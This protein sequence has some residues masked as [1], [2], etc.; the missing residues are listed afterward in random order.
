MALKPFIETANAYKGLDRDGVLIPDPEHQP[1]PGGSLVS[2]DSDGAV[3]Y[4]APSFDPLTGLFYVNAT[5]AFSIFYLPVDE[6]D[7]SGGRGSEYHTGAFPSSLR[8]LDYK[9]G[10]L[11]WEHK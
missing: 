9:T 2:P 4:P 3:N 10:A 1:S 11:K 5:S 7:P 6:K 8:A